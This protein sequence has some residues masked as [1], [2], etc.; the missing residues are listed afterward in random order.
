MHTKQ[1]GNV[2]ELAVASDL[3][4]QGYYVFSELG[5]ICKSDLIVMG[6]EYA[7]IKVQVKY[8]TP[9]SGAVHLR[10]TKAGPNYR[11]RYEAKHADVYAIFVPVLNLCLYVS[12]KE[13]LNK[14][15]ELTI[16]V[17]PTLNGNKTNI[18]SME[19]YKD[20]KR[21]AE[22]TTKEPVHL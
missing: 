17:S 22:F 1:F 2:G 12:S 6:N 3:A 20:F 11:F 9:K 18:N 14:K 13:L 19:G 10:S 4:A 15:S 21:A 8:I 5:D 16:R 7:P